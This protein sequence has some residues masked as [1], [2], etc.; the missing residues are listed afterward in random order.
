MDQHELTK[1]DQTFRRYIFVA[2]VLG[3]GLQIPALF[4]PAWFGL[5]LIETVSE[6]AQ[7]GAGPAF[8]FAFAFGVRHSG[9]VFGDDRRVGA[10]RPVVDH[11]RAERHHGDEDGAADCR[12][13]VGLGN[14]GAGHCAGGG[15]YAEQQ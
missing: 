7:E 15:E 12:N 5:G 14:E 10:S 6:F 1:Y 4:D 3:I 8:V 9:F 11:P 2:M 13:R